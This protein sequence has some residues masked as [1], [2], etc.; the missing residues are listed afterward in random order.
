MF[1]VFIGPPGAGKGTQAERLIDLL[2]I[3]HVSTGDLLRKAIS[4]GTELGRQASEYMQAGKLVPDELVL[5][6]IGECLDDPKLQGGALF[7]GFPRN[8]DQAKALDELLAKRGTPLALVLELQVDKDELV[9]RLLARKRADDNLETITQRLEV[10]RNETAPV[11]KHY[12][13]K[14]LL[15]PI[16]GQ[17]TPDDVFDRI[18][19]IVAKQQ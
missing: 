4:D 10:Y 6:I 3:A 7:D 17:G 11:L 5:G 18:K 14:G 19:A 9:Q 13:D 16:D 8:V 2:K 15:E 12:A 1:V